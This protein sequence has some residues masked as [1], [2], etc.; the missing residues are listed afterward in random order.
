[1][2]IGTRVAVLVSLFSLSILPPVVMAGSGPPPRE[3]SEVPD[4]LTVTPDGSFPYHVIINGTAGPVVG[5]MVEVEF[6]PEATALIAWTVPIP[7]GADTPTTGPGGGL[8]F[9]GAT[10]ANGEVTFYVAGSGCVAHKNAAEQVEPYIAQVRAD[11]LVFNEIGVNSPDAVDGDGTLPEF[12][13]YS[14]CDQAT[15]TSSVGL[16][17]ALYHTPQIKQ[18]SIEICTKFADPFTDPVGLADAGLLTPYVKAG[19]AGSCVYTGP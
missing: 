5:S 15:G 1:M 7:P 9:S 19:T 6:S 8:Q 17:D 13:Q 16:A 4:M 2:A 18:G 14:I 12:L 11:N 3:L 10:D